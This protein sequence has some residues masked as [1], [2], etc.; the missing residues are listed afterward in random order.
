[1]PDPSVATGS[2]GPAL[3][4]N[5][6]AIGQPERNT[7]AR[8]R[9]EPSPDELRLIALIISAIEPITRLIEVISRIRF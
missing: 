1:M 4:G 8:H 3:G 7:V 6:P 9:R 2:V 5:E